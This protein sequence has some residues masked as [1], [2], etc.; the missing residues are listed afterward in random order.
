MLHE[1]GLIITG[2]VAGTTEWLFCYVLFLFLEI[3]AMKVFNAEKEGMK[4][5]WGKTQ[6]S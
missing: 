3:K 6:L 1:G 2:E 4:V 5:K